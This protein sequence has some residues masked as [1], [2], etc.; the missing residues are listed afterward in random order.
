MKR[1]RAPVVSEVRT[2][3][4]PMPENIV[5]AADLLMTLAKLNAAGWR[6]TGLQAVLERTV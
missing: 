2:V 3:P 6:V 1:L 5:E 4:L